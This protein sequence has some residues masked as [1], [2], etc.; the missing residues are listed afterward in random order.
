MP[1]ADGKVIRP[2]LTKPMAAMVVA[3]EDCNIAVL[4]APVSAPEDGLRV[5][6]INAARIV[7]PSSSR[8]PCVITIRPS[9][10]NPIPPSNW[11]KTLNV[12][13]KKPRSIRMKAGADC[14]ILRFA[15]KIA[16]PILSDTYYISSLNARM[17][18]GYEQ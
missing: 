2:A 7:P 1:S 14:Q 8:R 13:M 16:D 9:R 18:S 12:L 17:S 5:N 6:L 11:S 15:R 3:L 4:I 10:N